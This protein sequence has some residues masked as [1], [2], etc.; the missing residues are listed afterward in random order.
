VLPFAAREGDSLADFKR[1]VIF[2]VTVIAAI[3]T[4]TAVAGEARV[5]LLV[6]FA[7][8]LGA[9]V[10]ASSFLRRSDTRTRSS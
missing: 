9:L 5:I 6:L 10:T 8:S 3:L 1:R 4:A 7:G 2:V